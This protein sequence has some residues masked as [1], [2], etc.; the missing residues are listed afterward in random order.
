MQSKSLF[1]LRSPHVLAIFAIALVGV[2]AYW[3]GLTN[4]FLGDDFS[5]IVNN[6]PVHSLSN[7]SQFFSGSTFYSG[8]PDAPLR[9]IYYRPLMTTVFS[10]I[11]A[12]FG[13]N[14]VAYHILQL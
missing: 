8:M 6:I 11:Y 2:V 10:A 4:P 14:V 1:G 3:S 5:Q 7:I 13:A 12:I 9:G